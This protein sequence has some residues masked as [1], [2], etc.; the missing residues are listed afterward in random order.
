M[1]AVRQRVP[2]QA[3]F[4]LY[5]D[6]DFRMDRA[7]KGRNMTTRIAATRN[8]QLILPTIGETIG[9]TTSVFIPFMYGAGSTKNEPKIDATAS[10]PL[11]VQIKSI[12][13]SPY[14]RTTPNSS[15]LRSDA[16]RKPSFAAMPSLCPFWRETLFR[17]LLVFSAISDG[18][19]S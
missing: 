17:G 15:G 16:V 11:L 14:W 4:S 9:S 6:L 18:T 19:K 1:A 10:G 2:H 5:A 13:A 8:V 7:M 12:A 3:Y